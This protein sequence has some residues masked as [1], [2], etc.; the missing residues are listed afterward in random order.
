MG[1]VLRGRCCERASSHAVTSHGW[2]R[3]SILP[4]SSLLPWLQVQATEITLSAGEMFYLPAGWVTGVRLGPG[5]QQISKTGRARRVVTRIVTPHRCVYD[6]NRVCPP[7]RF[8][9]S[10]T[11]WPTSSRQSWSTYGPRER[12]RRRSQARSA[13]PTASADRCGMLPRPPT[14]CWIGCRRTAR[15]SPWLR[16]AWSVCAFGSVVDPDERA[17]WPDELTLRSTDSRLFA[18]L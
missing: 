15:Y 13:S 5:T 1:E 11:T 18:L 12:I 10:S 3:T 7:T 6:N 16:Q 14:R 9:N 17:R 4:P 2:S 8:A